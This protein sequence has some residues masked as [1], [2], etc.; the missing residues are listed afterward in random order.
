MAKKNS[1]LKKY[2]RD[3]LSQT[4]GEKAKVGELNQIQYQIK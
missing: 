2:T 1:K 4:K 3:Y